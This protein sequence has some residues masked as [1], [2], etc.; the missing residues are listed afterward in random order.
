[1]HYP[2]IIYLLIVLVA[3][4]CGEMTVASND[5]PQNP[6][7]RSNWMFERRG[8]DVDPQKILNAK[9]L[10][11]KKLT[12]QQEENNQR[13]AGLNDWDEKGP[14]GI[15]GRSRCVAIDPNNSNHLF[16][17]AVSGG[18]WETSDGGTN[19]SQ[20]ND[21]LG[22]LTVMQIQYDPFNSNRLFASTGEGIFNGDALP[23]LGVFVST[24]NGAT[25]DPLPM[26]AG[27]NF[28]Y[29]N[30][31]VSDPGNQDWIYAVTTVGTPGNQ[32]NNGT[33]YRST[34]GGENWNLL[35]NT[36]TGALDI[37]ID[38]FDSD[39]ILVGC[40]SHLYLSTNA[41]D[42]MPTFTEITGGTNQI[43][44]NAGR[45][46]ISYC[47][48]NASRVYASVEDGN[49]N[50]GEIW[51]S[52]DGGAT[53]TQRNGMGFLVTQGWYDN[54]VFV[55]PTNSARIIVGGI[56]LWRSTDGGNTL[57]RISRWQ[58]DI[59]GNGNGNN[60]SIHADQHAIVP[61]NNYN[62]GSNNGVYIANDGGLYSTNNIW[63]VT[64]NSGWI[65]NVGDMA[66][67]QF[68]GGSISEDGSVVIGGSQDNSFSFSTDGG[69]NWSQPVTGD[70]AY[71][72]VNFDN[73][74]I[75][76][77]NINNN[78]IFQ[79]TDKG[80]TWIRIARFT[81]FLNINGNCTPAA[82]CTGNQYP[83]AGC[84]SNGVFYV[85][86]FCGLIS[87]FVMDP[88]DPDIILAGCQ[89]L[90]RNPNA[91]N[92]N[93]WTSIKNAVGTSRISAIDVDFGNSQ[94]IWVGY[95]NG[96]LERTTNTGSSWSGNI[97]PASTFVTDVCVNPNNS[98]EVIVSFGGYNQTNLFY[99]SNGNATTPSWTNI[100][101]GIDL[102]INSVEWHPDNSNWIYVGT[103]FGV[104]ASD[105]KGQ[106]WNITPLNDA[107]DGPVNTE[108]SELFWQPNSTILCAA[109]HGRGIWCSNE[110]RDKIYVDKNFV[111]T[112]DGTISNPFNTFKE[113]LDAAG[114]GSE[115]IFLSG[116]TYNEIPAVII[117]TRRIK[118]TLDPGAGSP[119][120]IE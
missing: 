11:D 22:A 6:L 85:E 14:Q 49:G 25:W 54:V 20:A 79:S 105:D 65:S 112:E 68:Y 96:T 106:N 71:S 43:P 94:R 60:N 75:I 38:P 102:Q 48:S 5:K 101:L 76:Y 18:I 115:I 118:V 97:S 16:F 27:N 33:I 39:N 28:F 50:N 70:G 119:V 113:A 83:V 80:T 24:D 7:E 42:A 120:I 1:M 19:W 117:E 52:E 3:S 9:K 53:W 64:Q 55:D 45:I 61:F 57:T 109:T 92:A 98:N 51:R 8:K 116:G 4:D 13:D 99:T 67:T 72:A 81:T 31:I 17:G 59:N 63:T 34:D 104:M 21:F 12:L 26:P 46:E 77:S 108:V 69:S 78:S 107:H 35:Q 88:N 89:E 84:V 82:C 91:G 32:V 103:D 56:D 37:K 44:A 95:R 74:S 23:G 15:G 93:S 58:D 10:F 41:E 36:A 2:F 86:D 73:D 100:N 111:G 47:P 87:L 30:D 29:V 114:N 40:N 62:G 66:V 110:I 90:W